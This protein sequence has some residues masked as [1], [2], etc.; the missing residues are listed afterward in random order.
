MQ[1]C[2]YQ[3]NILHDQAN[4]GKIIPTLDFSRFTDLGTTIPE[5]PEQGM[6]AI[7][8]LI[9]KPPPPDF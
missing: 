5:M 7:A 6:G 2:F 1:V 8:Q 3:H 4:K 9:N